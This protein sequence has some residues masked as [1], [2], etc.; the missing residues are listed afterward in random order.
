MLED[1]WMLTG[2]PRTYLW[3]DSR[4][5][6]PCMFNVLFYN[7]LHLLASGVSSLSAG[8]RATWILLVPHTSFLEGQVTGDIMA[9]ESTP[10]YEVRW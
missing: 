5:R 3:S 10:R 4:N 7:V 6:W 1:G 9:A 8:S 2:M